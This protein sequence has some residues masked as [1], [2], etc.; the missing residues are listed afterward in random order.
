MTEDEDFD[1][2]DFG[3]WRARGTPLVCP[4]HGPQEGGLVLRVIPKK[5]DEPIVRK[6][7]ALCVVDLLDRVG[8]AL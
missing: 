1:P 4:R 3:A 8:A 7:C 5:G 2:F 6:Y